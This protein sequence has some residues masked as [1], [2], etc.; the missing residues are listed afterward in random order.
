VGEDPGQDATE[1]GGQLALGPAPE[2]RPGPDGLEHRLLDHVGG[3]E[4]AAQFPVEVQLS[5]H[6][7]VLAE[8]FQDSRRVLSH[9]R[10]SF[11]LFPRRRR[12]PIDEPEFFSSGV[13]FDTSVSI[14]F[15]VAFNACP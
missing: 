1:P 15:M 2:L 3:V 6:L 10:S 5:Q 14:A 12:L 11:S 13:D 4:L 7:E 9:G 8:R